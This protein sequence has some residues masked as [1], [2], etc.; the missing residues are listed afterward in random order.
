[1]EIMVT[2]AQFDERGP[3]GA[4]ADRWRIYHR[5]PQDVRWAFMS[6]DSARFEGAIIDGE[7]LQQPNPLARDESRLCKMMNSSPGDLR[8]LCLQ[9]ANIDIEQPVMVGIDPMGIDVRARFD[10]VRVPAVHRMGSAVEA[11]RVLAAM[12]KN[13]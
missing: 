8:R 4:A 6:I 7:A 13:S 11:T 9:H 10:I 1:M 2:L 5:E 3:E 12:L